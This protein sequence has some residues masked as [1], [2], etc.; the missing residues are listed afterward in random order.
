MAGIGPPQRSDT[1]QEK[2]KSKGFVSLPPKHLRSRSSVGRYRATRERAA[3]NGS[4]GAASYYRSQIAVK[5]KSVVPQ[6]RRF[7][8]QRMFLTQ[9][10]IIA[11]ISPLHSQS[12]QAALNSQI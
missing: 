8:S 3:S 10:G 9:P 7:D 5:Q 11:V 12:Y 1:A 4:E 2:G 6:N